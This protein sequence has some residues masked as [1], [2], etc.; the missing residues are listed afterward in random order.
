M[1][2]VLIGLLLSSLIAFPAYLK[3]SLSSTGTIGAL[4][5]GTLIYCFGGV[6]FSIIMFSFFISSSLLT[7]Y[8]GYVKSK[9]SF[10][11]EKGGS[12]D[13]FQVFANGGVGLF[14]AA[15]YYVYKEPA[16][17][18]AY[19]ASFAESNADTWASEIGV[20][21]SK[22][23]ISIIN[24]RPVEK[25]MS[26]GIS[27]KGTLASLMGAG[28]I[29]MIFSLGYWLQHK[30]FENLFIYFALC[31]GIGFL[32]GIIDSFLGATVQ[33]GYYCEELDKFTEKAEFKGRRNKLVKGISFFNN[34]AVNLTSNVLSVCIMLVVYKIIFI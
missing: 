2:T 17:I 18:L 13:I 6:Y 10:T 33:A 4:I 9:G 26:G 27:W 20:L 28:F 11:E 31:T 34:D 15:L 12:R 7:K 23:P 19:A 29:G 25:G 3:K 14:M 24:L 8:K 1:I 30:S 16:F 22:S 5:L 32:G 21:S